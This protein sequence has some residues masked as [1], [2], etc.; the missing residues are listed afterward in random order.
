MSITPWGDH[1]QLSSRVLGILWY[2]PSAI[3]F[4]HSTREKLTRHWSPSSG[5]TFRWE[6]SASD[7]QG[8]ANSTDQDVSLSRGLLS[9]PWT[10]TAVLSP[11]ISH[12]LMAGPPSR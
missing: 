2:F 12:S 3:S 9:V 6:C 11:G 1:T 7:F 8:I 10:W 5:G 4:R